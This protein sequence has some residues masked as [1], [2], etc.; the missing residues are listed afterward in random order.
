MKAMVLL[1]ALCLLGLPVAALA[2]PSPAA[3]HVLAAARAQCAA[4]D[5]TLKLRR[6]A[7]SRLDLNGDGRDDEL[8]DASRMTC[9]TA[10]SAFCGTGGCAVTAIVAGRPSEFLARG[11]KRVSLA[12]GP[13]LLLAVHGTMCGTIGAERCVQ[14]VVFAPD[15]R[16]R[17]PGAP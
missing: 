6:G 9:S 7:V 12:G 16:A 17:Q 4:L 5:G 14:A 10:A 3:Q 11:W 15:G 8:V 2:A 1:A 13:V